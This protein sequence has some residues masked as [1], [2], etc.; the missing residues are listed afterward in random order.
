MLHFGMK[1]PFSYLEFIQICA[2]RIS[3]KD[4]NILKSLS[5]QGEYS[6]ED[7]KTTIVKKWLLFE[8]ALRNELVKIRAARKHID[9]VKYLRPDADADLAFANIAINA[10]RN[11]SILETERMLDEARWRKLDELAI[12]HYFDLD[13]LI[14]Y[15]Y[16][17]LI[18]E[19]WE[20]IRT[21]DSPRLLEETLI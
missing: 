18:L 7:A 15:A 20:R 13:S 2:G 10:Y 5:M 8:A 14:I 21:A 1:P 6:A 9:P 4:I 16:K 11:P 3:E 17:L 12:G 19:R